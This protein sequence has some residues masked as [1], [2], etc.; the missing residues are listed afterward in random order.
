M[1]LF[2]TGTG[3]GA[4]DTTGSQA[5]SSYGSLDKSL[6]AITANIASF[7]ALKTSFQNIE[8]TIIGIADSS[9]AL[10]RNMGGVVSNTYD[11]QKRLQSAYKDTLNIGASFQDATDA[12]TGLADGMGK[13]V[14]PSAETVK[15][16]IVLSKVTGMS[17]KEI[18]TMVTTMVRFG[19]TQKE[20]VE[21]IS[22]M[23]QEAR[24]AGLDGQ[25]FITAIGKDYSKISGFGFKSGVDGLK[26]MVEQSMT[27]RTNVESIG[28]LKLQESVLDPEG[29]IQAAA[30]FQMLGGAVGKLGDPFQLLYMAQTNVEGLQDELVKSAKS[31]AMF[32]KETGQ[33]D[34]STQDMYRLREQAKIT[35]ANLEDLVNTGREA[36]KLDYIKEKF[37]LDGLPEDQ[38]KLISQLATVGKDGKLTVDIP[39]FGEIEA[40]DEQQ[41]K[42]ALSNKDAQSALAEYQKNATL[43]DRKI[44]EQ[45]LTV[46]ERQQITTNEI[47][48]AVLSMMSDTQLKTFTQKTQETNK[49]LQEKVTEQ[50]KNIADGLTGTYTSVAEAQN[51]TVDALTVS[52]PA[53]IQQVIDGGGITGPISTSNQTAIQGQDMIF[54]PNDAPQLLAKGKIYEGIVGDEIAIGTNLTD[55]LN[56]GGGGI[57]GKIDININLTGSIG[58]DPGQLSKMFNSP[59]VQKQIMDTV[60]YKLNDYKRQQGVIS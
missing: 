55:A 38:Q 16:M 3:T 13:I 34:V 10:Q 22:K 32:N 51:T 4:A 45:T 59:Q 43:S 54:T 56:K 35:G 42:L 1:L 33:F 21:K 44:A 27:L 47:K 17:T 31:A 49:L 2:D 9:L 8:K 7:D 50:S 11:F 40:T 23:A 25:K 46:Q 19:G 37:N 60:L 30:N 12:V 58:G 26:K 39:G 57:G 15:N 48:N 36:A 6:K 28:A 14:S 52:L 18:G 24:R 5:E 53:A 20:A 29:A 41:L